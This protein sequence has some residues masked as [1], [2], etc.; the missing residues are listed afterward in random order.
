[1][2]VE[3]VFSPLHACVHCVTTCT[4]IAYSR[5]HAHSQVSV[6]VPWSPYDVDGRNYDWR[7]L[8]DAADLVFVMAYDTQVGG[9]DYSSAAY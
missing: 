5:T 6:D 7:G 1:M 9:C 4:L 8:A 2:L 3:S